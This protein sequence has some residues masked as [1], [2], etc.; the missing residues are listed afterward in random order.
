MQCG[1]IWPPLTRA[2]HCELLLATDDERLK[3][4]VL[5]IPLFSQLSEVRGSA[6]LVELHSSVI[7][8][9]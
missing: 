1:Q 8:E 7:T 5:H 9:R 3:T 4:V 2:S 6:D